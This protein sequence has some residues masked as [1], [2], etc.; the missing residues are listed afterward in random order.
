[1]PA[2]SRSRIAPTAPNVA[3]MSQP[4]SALKRGAKAP[5]SPCAAPPL[6]TTSFV[7]MPPPLPTCSQRVP[8]KRRH[9]ATRALA[10][11]VPYFSPFTNAR[12]GPLKAVS[13]VLIA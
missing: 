11:I 1:M 10:G 8:E 12:I 6:R 7:D 13:A 2:S 3:S 9:R 4:V 5:T